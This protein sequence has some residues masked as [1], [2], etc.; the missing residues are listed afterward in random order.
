MFGKEEQL[1]KQTWLK[2]KCTFG[3]LSPQQLEVGAFQSRSRPTQ[4]TPQPSGMFFSFYF[5]ENLG[6]R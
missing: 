2:R 6:F 5:F 4:R 3:D 1:T